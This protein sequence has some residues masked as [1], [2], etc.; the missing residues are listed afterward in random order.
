MLYETKNFLSSNF[1]IKDLGEA[2]YVLGIEIHRDRT[3]GV[4]GLSQKAY[5]EKMLA[6]Y[7]MDKCSATPVPFAKGDKFGDYQCPKN[8]LELDEMRDKPYASD[9]GSLMYAQVCT[10]PDLAYVTEM[11]G[12]YQKNP[13]LVHWKGVKKALR[14]CQGSKNLMLIYQRS[15]TLEIMG[16][17]D[18]DLG[19]C[20]DNRRS[21]TG[22]IF[23]LAGGAIS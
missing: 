5:I 20:V 18:A 7:N 2:S 17:S 8:K 22:Y 16:Y 13:G 12:R 15:D 21:T 9:V 23:T 1:D 19:G 14:Y 10:R 4:S 11:L 6:R 3:K